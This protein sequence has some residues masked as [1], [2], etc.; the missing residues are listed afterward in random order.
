MGLLPIFTRFIGYSGRNKFN[1]L[2]TGKEISVGIYVVSKKF[3]MNCF[4]NLWIG[5]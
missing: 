3:L 1:T 2:K 4:R 5:C